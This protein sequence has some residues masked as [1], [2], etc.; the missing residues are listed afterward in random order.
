MKIKE[1][2][3]NRGIKV[4]GTEENG[5]N[6]DKGKGEWKERNNRIKETYMVR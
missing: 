3:E 1:D 4:K 2:G 5:E 6:R